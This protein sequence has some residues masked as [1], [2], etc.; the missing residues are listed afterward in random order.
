MM[1]KKLLA[2]AG[3]VAMAAAMSV[4]SASAAQ[5]ANKGC[6]GESVSRNAREMVPYGQFNRLWTVEQL[7]RKGRQLRGAP[8]TSWQL[9][10]HRLLEHLQRLRLIR[11]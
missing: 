11:P 5:P 10:R 1:M 4:G 3:V 8:D 9:L 7:R 2:C 6:A